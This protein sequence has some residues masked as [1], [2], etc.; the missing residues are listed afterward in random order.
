MG[1][2][3][4]AEAN[5]QATQY[6]AEVAI[7]AVYDSNVVVEEVDISS[8]QSDYALTLNAKLGVRS[9]VSEKAKFDLSYNY[10][11]NKY[12]EFSRVNR[13]THIL[14]ANLELDTGKIDSG[15][16]F[17]Y[18]NSRLDNHK[19]LEFY[20]VSPSL[21]GFLARK[22]FARGAYVYSDKTIENSA[23]RDAVSNAGELDLYFFRRGLRS[24]FNFGY[25]YKYEN[26]V[27]SQYD[28]RSDSLKI[29]YIHRFDLLSRT[30]TL[31]LAYRYEDRAYNSV[32]PGID[33]KR[34]DQR[35]RW[36][37]DLEIPVI[38]KGAIQFYG[39]YGDYESNL[40]R[41]DYDQSIIGTRFV[42]RW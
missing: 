23:A 2:T 28:Y 31:G 3:A 29:R 40:P 4:L 15:V 37:V 27:A 7:G 20:R 12:A 1:T 30:A 35:Q 22:W 6:S 39:G 10:S 36:R 32:T 9:Q 38:E 33:E 19:F 42:Y 41:A 21:S 34:A 26:A 11:Q 25:R 16:S 18:I 17:F 8:S 24:Y 5:T 14:G 13:Q